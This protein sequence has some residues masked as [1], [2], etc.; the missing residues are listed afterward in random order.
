MPQGSILGPL[1]FVLACS[2][3]ATLLSSFLVVSIR[4]EAS[5]ALRVGQYTLG[6]LI[7][8]GGMIELEIPGDL[9]YGEAG[10]P[11]AGIGPNATLVFEVELLEIKQDS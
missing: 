9:G 7:G 11:P 10:M 6:E 2:A 4:K 5:E 1:L 8:E 3:A